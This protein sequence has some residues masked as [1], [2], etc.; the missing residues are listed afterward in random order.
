MVPK[1][2]VPSVSIIIVNWNGKNILDRCLHSLETKTV[3]PNYY[4]ILVDNGSTDGSVMHVRE[5]HK[6]I[7]V[8]PLDKNYGFSKGCNFGIL[9]AHKKYSSD[10]YLLLNNDTEIVQEDWLSEMISVAE[11]D[12]RLG[13]LGCILIFPDGRIQ[14]IGI[15]FEVRGLLWL[16]IPKK[17]ILKRQYE[18]DAVLGACF[19]IKKIVIDKI[20]LLDE[21]YSPFQNE[22]SDFC[23]RAKKAGFKIITYTG[24]KIVHIKSFSMDKVK[25]DYSD[26]IIRKNEIRFIL[27]NFPLSWMVKR[28]PYEIMIF[29]R[30]FLKKGG[31]KRIKLRDRNDMRARSRMYG[32]AWLTNFK[33][34]PEIIVKRWNRK[35]YES[36]IWEKG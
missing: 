1:N 10:Y 4:V 34:L 22:E 19:L 17:L 23:A 36:S 30:C 29:L 25:V 11:G 14:N 32:I 5:N 21:G 33:N 31:G 2:G 7:D 9:Y 26:L 20:G 12:E 27:L 6:W 8:L 13:I 18:V 24:V 3:Y 16:G 15:T 35:S 28:F